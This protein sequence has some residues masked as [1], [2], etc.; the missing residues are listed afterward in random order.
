M[1]R[2]LL[3]ITYDGALNLFIRA[4]ADGHRERR[5]AAKKSERKGQQRAAVGSSLDA[6]FAAA[7]TAGPPQRHKRIGMRIFHRHAA[8]PPVANSAKKKGGK[9]SRP[10]KDLLASVYLKLSPLSPPR[11]SCLL[12]CVWVGVCYHK[13]LARESFVFRAAAGGSIPKKPST[14]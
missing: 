12:P 13:L 4:R 8:C 1:W 11:S 9:A 14:Q 5:T 10:P 6:T 7:A 2:D 3:R